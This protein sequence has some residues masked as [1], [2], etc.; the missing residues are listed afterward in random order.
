MKKIVKESLNEEFDP[1]YGGTFEG[2][3][4][5]PNAIDENLKIKDHEFKRVKVNNDIIYASKEGILGHDNVFISWDII[6]KLKR[7]V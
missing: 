4:P 7:A 5:D 6:E 3:L 1:T 2:P